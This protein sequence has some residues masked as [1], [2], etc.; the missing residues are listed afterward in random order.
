MWRHGDVL[1]EAVREIPCGARQRPDAVLASGEV[2]GHCHRVQD[3]RSA[4]LFHAGDADFLEVQTEFAV[5]THEEHLPIT[6]PRGTYRFWRQREYTPQAIR[7]V[8]D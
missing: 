1:I 7:T 6:L 4:R 8:V 5:I 3:P 2:T